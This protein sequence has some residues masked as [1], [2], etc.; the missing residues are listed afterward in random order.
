MGSSESLP[1]GFEIQFRSLNFQAMRNG[2]LMCIT[3][4]GRLGQAPFL[5]RLLLMS[6]RPRRLS[7]T[8]VSMAFRPALVP[9][10]NGATTTHA[11]HGTA[12]RAH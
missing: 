3:N 5:A 8:S 11:R 6:L 2:Y 7:G 4:R 9:I 1:S 10:V 12:R